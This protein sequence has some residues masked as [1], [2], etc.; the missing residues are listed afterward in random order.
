MAVHELI[1]TC[2]IEIIPDGL[3]LLTEQHCMI[4]A[5]MTEPDH[6]NTGIIIGKRIF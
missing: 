1:R 4:Y 3:I 6:A 2:L 5:Y